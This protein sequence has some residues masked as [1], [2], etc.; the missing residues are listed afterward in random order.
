MPLSC[1]LS[2]REMSQAFSLWM[3]ATGI[4]G[5]LPP[6]TDVETVT[7]KGQTPLTFI[8]QRKLNRVLLS[9]DL[10]GSSF[11]LACC[12]LSYIFNLDV[13][14]I[15]AELYF[16]NELLF[17]TISLKCPSITQVKPWPVWRQWW[18]DALD[19]MNFLKNTDIFDRGGKVWKEKYVLF[20]FETTLKSN[21][22][23]NKLTLMKVKHS[24]QK[25]MP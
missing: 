25:Q 10:S 23:G 5:Q 17:S 19:T 9:P 2:S 11:L 3:R 14:S 15:Y 6:V 12:N 20:Y 8:L 22:W 24:F 1:F 21:F 16:L 18:W 4:L 7:Q 13:I